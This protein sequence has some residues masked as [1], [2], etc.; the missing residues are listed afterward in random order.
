MNGIVN[1]LAESNG[2]DLS[3]ENIYGIEIVS[4]RNDYNPYIDWLPLSYKIFVTTGTSVHYTDSIYYAIALFD[5]IDSSVRKYERISFEKYNTP[6]GL[7][8][9]N[10]TIDFENYLRAINSNGNFESYCAFF[11]KS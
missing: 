1:K 9:R 8:I 10:I 3:T 6:T 2:I 11:L 5:I 7:S 4:S